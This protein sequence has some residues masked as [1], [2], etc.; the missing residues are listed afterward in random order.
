VIRYVDK[1]DSLIPMSASLGPLSVTLGPLTAR[2]KG[3]ASWKDHY[4]EDDY[5]AWQDFA[6]ECESLLGFLQ[7]HGALDRF[8]PRLCSKPQQRDEAINEI[9]VAYYLDSVGYPVI[10]WNEPVDAAGYSVEFAVSLG[11]P[12][13]AFVEVKS[14]GWES[15][16]SDAERKQGRAKQPKYIGIHGGAAGPVQVIRRAVEKARP[17]FSGNAPSIVVVSDDCFVNLGE[18]GWEPLQMALLQKSVAYGK[19]LFHGPEYANVGAV[20]LFWIASSFK[21]KSLCMVNPNAVPMAVVPADLATRLSTRPIKTHV[22][23]SPQRGVE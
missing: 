10:D 4:P 19:G 1:F 11:S 5:P 14:P 20:C 3:K 22:D 2:L 9:R 17:K 8:W 7:N 13:Y 6:D 16:L 21:Y 18:W 23:L 12:R 15:E